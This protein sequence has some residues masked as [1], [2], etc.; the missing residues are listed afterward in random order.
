MASAKDALRASLLSSAN[1]SSGSKEP[2]GVL[3]A[4]PDTPGD[5]R[6]GNHSLDCVPTTSSYLEDDDDGAS[7]PLLLLPVLPRLLHPSPSL[8]IMLLVP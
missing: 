8:A 7:P 1:T 4:T 6:S 3:T 5:W 2:D